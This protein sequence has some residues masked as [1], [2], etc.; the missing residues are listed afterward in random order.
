MLLRCP[1]REG[2]RSEEVAIMKKRKILMGANWGI[3][4]ALLL[5]LFVIFNYLSYRHFKRFDCTFSENYSLSPQTEKTLAGLKD[6]IDIIVLLPAGDEI[7]ERVE[8]LLETFRSASSKVKVEFLDPEK[9]REQYELTAKKFSV[10]TP[11]SVVFSYK[12]SSKW[13]E[14]D[15]LVDYDFSTESYAQPKIRSFKAEGAFLNAILEVIDPRRPKIYFT[16]GHGEKRANEENNRGISLFRERLQREGATIEELQTF[17][18]SDI[19]KDASLVAV[20][21]VARPF[22]EDEAKTI[23]RYLA[24]GGKLLLLLDPVIIEGKNLSF[25]KTGLEGLCEKWGIGLDPDIVV[26]P[27]GTLVQM[28]AQTFFAVNYSGHKIV[29]DLGQNKYPLLFILSRNLRKLEPQDK[30]YAAEELVSTSPDA[31]GETDLRDLKNVSIGP[32]DPKGVLPL[33]IA[34]SSGKENKKARIVA[35][36]DSDLFSDLAFLSPAGGNS[37]FAM[38]VYHFLL[39]MEERIAI[40]PK[41]MKENGIALTSNQLITNFI[42]LVILYPFLIG[43][44][45]VFTYFSRRR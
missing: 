37:I 23:D 45:G 12:D 8:R 35:A 32:D 40:P 10:T 36:G 24:S 39:S 25:G 15:Q 42:L 33:A 1:L 26:D 21:Q 18:L 29:S 2:S 3:F 17:G 19:P 6:D 28:G 34:V 22:T 31:W 43:L 30:D 44:L 9:D 16:I 7:Y 11:N 20:V 5:A 14:K 38:N 4:V 27:K 13:V 41:E